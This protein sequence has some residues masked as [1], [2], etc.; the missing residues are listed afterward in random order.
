L[1]A[2]RG[3]ARAREFAIRAAVGATRAQIVRQ[4]LVESFVVAVLGGMLGIFIALWVR[5]AL[6]ALSPQGV[7]RFQEISFDFRVLG[8]A[9]LLAS[10]TSVLF[11]LWPAWQASRA[12]VQIA[13]KSGSHGSAFGQANPG[14]ARH[15]RNRAHSHFAHRGRACFEKLRAHAIS[16]TRIRAAR[17]ALRS[18]GAS[19]SNL[20]HL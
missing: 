6:V 15:H 5:D 8:F 16:S 3:A 14:L 13:L 1:F 4:L 20:F 12:D 19:I 2:A 17:I 10:L 18:R 7:S 11:G 9:L